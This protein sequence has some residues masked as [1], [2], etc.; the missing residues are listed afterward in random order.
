MTEPNKNLH[1]DEGG[2]VDIGY[3]LSIH[4]QG[5]PYSPNKSIDQIVVTGPNGDGSPISDPHE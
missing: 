5:M 1:A 4:A 2:T 3:G